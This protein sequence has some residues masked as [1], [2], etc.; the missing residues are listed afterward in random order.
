MLWQ[1]ALIYAG[2]GDWYVIQNVSILTSDEKEVFDLIN[3][4][5]TKNG[6][7]SLKMDQEML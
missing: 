4:H 6:L 3:A 2:I 5:R 1:I 7:Q